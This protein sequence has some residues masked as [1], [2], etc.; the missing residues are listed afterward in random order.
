MVALKPAQNMC[1]GLLK[2]VYVQGRGDG[3]QAGW[4]LCKHGNVATAFDKAHAV[5]GM[6]SNKQMHLHAGG[7]C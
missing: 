5:P 6:G 1:E 3:R 2:I 7:C 4:P